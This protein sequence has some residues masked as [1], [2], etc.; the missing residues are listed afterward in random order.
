MTD[1]AIF[2]PAVHA[3]D[4]EGNPITNRDGSFR[5][6]RSDAGR[7]T[8]GSQS[9]G[10]T[11]SPR[12]KYREGVAGLMQIPSAV[13]SLIDP[14]DGFCVAQHTA[15]ISNALAD[16]A[17]ERPEFAAALDRVMAVGPYGALVGAVFG[18]GIQLAHNHGIVPEA[19][20]KSMGATPKRDIER[21]LKGSVPEPA[22]RE[23]EGFPHEWA[24]DVSA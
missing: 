22:P 17:V 3:S 10:S 6:K 5:K 18:L 16:L 13:I 21:H 20:A 19:M 9:K 14:V 23:D 2:D 4:K 24:V 11:G 12:D 8:N 1:N 7:K 15:P